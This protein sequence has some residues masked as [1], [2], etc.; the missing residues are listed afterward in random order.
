LQNNYAVNWTDDQTCTLT[1]TYNNEQTKTI[2]DY[3]E[4]GTNGL[5]IIYDRLFALRKNQ[6]WK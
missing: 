1:I 2:T 3:G 4:I 5:R 6:K